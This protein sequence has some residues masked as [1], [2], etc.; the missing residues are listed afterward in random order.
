MVKGGGC[1][2]LALCIL[3]ISPGRVTFSLM[4][5]QGTALEWNRTHCSPQCQL[6]T[7]SGPRLGQ[8]AQLPA[9]TKQ[10]PNSP[11]LG[12]A[13]GLLSR[14]ESPLLRAA[15]S[16]AGPQLLCSRLLL[17]VRIMVLLYPPSWDT[18]FVLHDSPTVVHS[19]TCPKVFLSVYIPV[20]RAGDATS[21]FR[22]KGFESSWVGRE[23]AKRGTTENVY[24]DCQRP[25]PGL[26]KH[27]KYNVK[28][29]E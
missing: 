25:A 24:G 15:G 28:Q 6:L 21:F 19:V 16:P 11:G 5:F 27:S 14:A 20:K 3:S 17:W 12:T 9:W 10:N 22:L 2:A 23:Y 13:W 29:K 26:L 4:L 7:E 18:Q 8:A 1:E